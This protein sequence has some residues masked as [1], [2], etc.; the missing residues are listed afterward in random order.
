MTKIKIGECSVDSGQIMIIDPCYVLHQKDHETPTYEDLLD[1]YKTPKGKD[2]TFLWKLGIVSGPSDGDGRY[3]VYAEKDNDGDITSLTIELK[4]RDEE[5][6]E[7]DD[8]D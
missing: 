1:V 3:P 6:E 5:D 4:L 2:G 7:E 8:E